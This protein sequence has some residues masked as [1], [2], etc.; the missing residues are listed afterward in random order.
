LPDWLDPAPF[1]VV[2]EE[3]PCRPAFVEVQDAS[4]QMGAFAFTGAD[5]AAADSA[6]AD[7]TWAVPAD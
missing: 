4:T 3:P 6:C 2:D 1:E 7:P 5:T